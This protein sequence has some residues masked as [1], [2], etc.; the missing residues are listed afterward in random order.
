VVH[1][2]KLYA[3]GGYDYGARRTIEVLA[4]APEEP[5]TPTLTPTPT[6]TLTPVPTPLAGRKH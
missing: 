6:P 3:I 5:A 1:D 2:D 4:L